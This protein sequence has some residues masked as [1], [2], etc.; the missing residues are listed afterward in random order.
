MYICIGVYVYIYLFVN[1]QHV[2]MNYIRCQRNM[3]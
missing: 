2:F 3:N 1:I